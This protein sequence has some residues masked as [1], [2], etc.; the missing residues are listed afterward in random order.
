MNISGAIS[1]AAETLHNAAV[2]NPRREA[3]SLLAFVLKKESSFLIAH[4]EYA[5]TDAEIAVFDEAVYR[6]KSGEP[7]QYITGHQEFYGLE[8]E[9]SPGVLIP[10][11]ET[12]ILVEEAVRL[13]SDIE[14]P[15]FFEI[16]VGSGCIAIS[17]LH[18]VGSATAVATD[19]SGDALSAAAR[20]AEKHNVALRLTLRQGDV[21]EGLGE[22]FDMIVSN[23]PYIPETEREHLQ[24]EVGQFEPPAALFGG[25]D[26]LAVV[27]RI[28]GGAPQF[29]KPNGFLLIEIGFDQSV[30]VKELFDRSVWQHVDFLDDLQGF[31]RIVKARLLN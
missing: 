14:A 9:V 31:P 16:G 2:A 15:V 7:F 21:S 19:I 6:R 27:R 3:S 26:G 30:S 12:E 20:N 5:L 28:I 10:R 17:I 1:S 8:F 23:P 24:R 22:K 18:S 29:L 25:P 11:P 4:P 13:L